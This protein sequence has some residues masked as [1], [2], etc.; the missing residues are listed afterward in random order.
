MKLQKRDCP[1]NFE[2]KRCV[3][4]WLDIV[5]NIEQQKFDA[6]ISY[7]MGPSLNALVEA[8]VAFNPEYPDRGYES[9]YV[10]YKKVQFGKNEDDYEYLPYLAKFI[11]DEEGSDVDW[12][13]EKV[14][15]KKIDFDVQLE[16]TISGRKNDGVYKFTVDYGDL[17]Y[18]TAKLCTEIIKKCGFWGYY[19]NY[20]VKHIDIYDLLY[21]KAWALKAT[22]ML[23]LTANKDKQLKSDLNKEL[24]LL[25]FDM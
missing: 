7:C 6:S 3:A 2:F 1:I 17:C 16:L 25:M 23:N 22:K 19:N 18:A 8:L 14:P 5:V 13:I 24:E 21:L 9:K 11:W 4:G 10:E 15:S 20:W 12:K